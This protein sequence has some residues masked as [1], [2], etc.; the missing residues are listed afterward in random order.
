MFNTYTGNDETQILQIIVLIR[1]DSE[2]FSGFIENTAGGSLVGLEG[3]RGQKN[4]RG[5]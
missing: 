3:L 4:G 5:T 1:S 2:K